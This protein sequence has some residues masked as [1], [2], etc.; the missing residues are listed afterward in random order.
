MKKGILSTAAAII[1]GAAALTAPMGAFA[2]E[3]NTAKNSNETQ[4]ITVPAR[5]H[6]PGSITVYGDSIPGANASLTD[7]Q[8]T[9][10]IILSKYYACPSTTYSLSGYTSAQLLNTLSTDN[11]KGLTDDLK[12][13]DVIVIS[14]GANDY[15][16]AVKE[17]AASLYPAL[18]NEKDPY[19]SLL[20]IVDS[21]SQSPNAAT[22]FVP[23]I[24]KLNSAVG[25][26]T[27]VALENVKKLCAEIKK[28]NPDCELIVQTIYNPA[29]FTEESLKA[30]L[31]AK[32]SNFSTGY[33]MLRNVFKNNLADF[34]EGLAEIEGIKIANINEAFT[35]DGTSGN[36]GYADVYTQI[37]SKEKHDFHPNALGQIAIASEL[38]KTI[39][40]IDIGYAEE[41]IADYFASLPNECANDLLAALSIR[42]GD[43]DKNGSVDASD[44]SKALEIYATAQSGGNTADVMTGTAHIALDVDRNGTIDASDASTILTH[45]TDVQ[46]GGKGIL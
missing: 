11:I 17:L 14:S 39:G 27:P 20:A 37:L 36:N 9:Y 32:P 26:A 46:S 35:V 18:Y 3:K 7:D 2:A 15:L 19:G 29:I 45:Y 10:G 33:S 1:I 38:M 22:E 42:I 13:S 12:N 28:L 21:I 6:S 43:S 34:N 40:Y 44:A 16:S 8:N 4:I 25:S 41:Y 23:L 31:A 30:L 24:S 5:T